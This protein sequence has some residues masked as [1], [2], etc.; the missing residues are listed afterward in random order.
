MKW[1]ALFTLA[2]FAVFASGCTS[3]SFLIANT[4]TLTG[5]YDRSTNHSYGPE[6]RQKL[7]V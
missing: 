3:L 1:V 2:S 4:A 7:D 5:R 6:A